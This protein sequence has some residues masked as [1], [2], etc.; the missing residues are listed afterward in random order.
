V[1]AFLIAALI[2]VLHL[3]IISLDAFRPVVK[4][5]I[6]ASA[7]IGKAEEV[8]LLS[9]SIGTEPASFNDGLRQYN[10]GIKDAVAL[11]FSI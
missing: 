8:V 7:R 1:F 9:A 2:A 4:L 10:V 6:F 3:C 5:V 11:D